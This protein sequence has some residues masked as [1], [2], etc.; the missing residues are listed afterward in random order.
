MTSGMRSLISH[1]VDKT[2]ACYARALELQP[3]ED[4]KSLR[5]SLVMGNIYYAHFKRISRHP[6]D[7]WN[8]PP[9]LSPM[10]KIWLTWRAW[11]Y[12]KKAAKKH[13]PAT[14]DV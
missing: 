6:S 12:E 8:H 2:E 9:R 13:L 7:L 11:R 3:A 4:R 14:F 5:P 10:H 1:Y